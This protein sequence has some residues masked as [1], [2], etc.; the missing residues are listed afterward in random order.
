MP[1]VALMLIQHVFKVCNFIADLLEK[2]SIKLI[3]FFNLK[4]NKL[5][6]HYATKCVKT[7]MFI[8]GASIAT[9]HG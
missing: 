4:I 3:Y 1:N 8:P 9:M 7:C 6:R 5:Y 2:P